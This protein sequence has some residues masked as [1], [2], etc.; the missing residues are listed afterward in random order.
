MNLKS[1]GDVTI[2]SFKKVHDREYKVVVEATAVGESIQ[3]EKKSDP[4]L[5]S[6]PFSSAR[7]G[8]SPSRQSTR[9]F[10]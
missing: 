7:L 10:R 6:F 9:L 8:R 4:I 1:T 3:L 2:K 5:S